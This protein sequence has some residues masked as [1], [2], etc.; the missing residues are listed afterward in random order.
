L[1]AAE[2]TEPAK[3]SSSSERVSTRAATARCTRVEAAIGVECRGAVGIIG[4]LLVGVG[5]D[6]VGG[7]G[8]GE[9]FFGGGFLVGVRVIFL[10]E[11]VVCFLDVGGGGVFIDAEGFVWIGYCGGW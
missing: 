3:S 1:G 9:L 4:L 11:A 6:F 10:C 8:S 5:Q 7:L 2:S